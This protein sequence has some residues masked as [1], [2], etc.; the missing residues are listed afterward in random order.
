MRRRKRERKEGE[1]EEREGE[2]WG[3]ERKGRQVTEPDGS[4][5]IWFNPETKKKTDFTTP[6]SYC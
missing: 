1:G 4:D 5:V 6:R 3:G 2:G